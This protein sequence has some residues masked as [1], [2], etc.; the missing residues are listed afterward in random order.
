[1]NPTKASNDRIT[2]SQ[3]YSLLQELIDTC[4]ESLEVVLLWEDG[5]RQPVPK[6]GRS[7]KEAARP[8]DRATALKLDTVFG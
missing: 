1:M 3:T 4:L 8:T 7:K 6:L 2:A 5:L